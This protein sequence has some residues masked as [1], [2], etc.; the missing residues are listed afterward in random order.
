M[1]AIKPL[2][3]YITVFQALLLA[4]ISWPS[5]AAITGADIYNQT[6]E[7]TP[8][9]NDQALQQYIE[10]LGNEVV[11]VS[12]MS[13]EKFIFT[14]LD[15][16]NL[17]AF[18][19]RDNYI[20]VNRGL[21][22]YVSN[23]AQL[24]A[25]LAHEVGHITREHVTGQ[26]SRMTGAQIISTLAGALSNSNEVYEAT[27]AYINSMMKSHGRRN[28][29]EADEAG[30]EYM[31]KLGYDPKA[32]LSMLGIMKDYESV[33]KKRAKGRGAVRPTY[34]GVF[35]SHPRN[36]ARLR[37]V[38][39]KADALKSSLNRGD[40]A[41]TYRELTDGLV[42]GVN[43]LA[44]TAPP[45]RYSNMDL[46]V[47]IDFPKTWSVNSE[48]E[49]GL[50]T[51][52]APDKTANITLKKTRRTAQAPEEYLFNYM[53][54]QQ[55]T[56]GQVISPAGLSGYTGLLPGTDGKPAQRIAVIYYKLDAY[57]IS[58]EVTDSEQYSDLDEAILS[59]IKTFRPI[60]RAEIAGQKPKVVKYLQVESSTTYA[61]LI[62]TYK[63]NASDEE[64]LRVINGH[65]P[66]GEP[67]PGQ[68]IKVFQQ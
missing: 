53:K 28:E 51:A 66:A 10:R 27:M 24:V 47:R 49:D 40:G 60:S 43:F 17:N 68:W 29:L 11:A 22:N 1:E 56:D 37:T 39:V 64:I 41:D 48:I 12:E 31:A 45:N 21:L 32:M 13:G 14:L 57:I 50:A 63:L 3:F 26:E 44:K 2:R 38:V 52:E 8:I 19:T 58:T 54:I 34:H 23:E 65:Y 35:A 25:V 5:S 46:K 62:K 18:A 7:K 16:E 59:A 4:L 67:K 30:A 36:D 61:E 15:D 9:Y 6:I 20:Y 55:L 33:Q 42:W